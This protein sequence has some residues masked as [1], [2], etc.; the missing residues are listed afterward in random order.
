[1]LKFAGKLVG[2]NRSRS[3]RRSAQN[4]AHGEQQAEQWVGEGL[5]IAGVDAPELEALVGSDARKVALAKL[6]WEKTTVSQGWI[7]RRL[8]M[9][10]PANVSQALRRISWKDLE[11]KLSPGLSKFLRKARG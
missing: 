1:M 5:R 4:L 11:K 3:Y 2:K 6:A 9:G 7:A 10:S 8:V